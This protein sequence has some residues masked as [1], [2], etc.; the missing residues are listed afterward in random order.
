MATSTATA[1]P[2][3]ETPMSNRN[4]ILNLAGDAHGRDF[5]DGVEWAT[6]RLGLEAEQ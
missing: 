5:A 6:S 2:C 3:K 4:D 1:E